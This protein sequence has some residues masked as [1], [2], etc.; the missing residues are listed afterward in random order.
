MRKK[1]SVLVAAGLLAG[2]AAVTPA[3]AATGSRT[4]GTGHTGCNDG[5]VTWSPTTIWPPNHKMQ[6]IDI[7]YT[8]SDG[9]GDNTSIT[10]T[11]I[12]DNQMTGGVEDV[13]A[14]NPHLTDWGGIGNTGSATDPNPATTTAQVR[15]ERSGPDGSR[16]Y[17]ITV[18]CKDS[19][20]ADVNDPSEA[21][22]QMGTANLTVTV[23][24]DQRPTG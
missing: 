11:A 1:S 22:G 23:P 13:G 9:D 4:S 14:G 18:T 15:A 6:T 19:G 3:L 24:H 17:T 10:V 16:V 21:T 5:T 12:T 7:A 8:D 20:G 2:T